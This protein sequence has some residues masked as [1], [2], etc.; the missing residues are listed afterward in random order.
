MKDTWKEA[1][2][3]DPYYSPNL[4]VEKEDFSIAT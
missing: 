2:S 4:T 3:C 1:L